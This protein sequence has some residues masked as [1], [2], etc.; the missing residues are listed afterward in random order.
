MDNENI[1]LPPI[2]DI[3][4]LFI[5]NIELLDIP[6]I[7]LPPIPNI[8]I[9]DIHDIPDIK[10][11]DI[12]DIPDMEILDIPD[13]E[14]PPIPYIIQPIQNKQL[15]YT[16]L[17]PTGLLLSDKLPTLSRFREPIKKIN[18]IHMK[19]IDIPIFN[20]NKINF[21]QI[22]DNNKYLYLKIS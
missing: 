11:L 20:K 6:N 21:K 5:A 19:N 7:E 13:I 17:T 15:I 9:L 3:E 22:Y 2:P 10:L 18:N 8:D 12:P 1:E 16:I 4:L 14:L